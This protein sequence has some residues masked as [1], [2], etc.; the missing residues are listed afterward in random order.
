[1]TNLLI[2]GFVLKALNHLTE[3]ENWV[4]DILNKHEGKCLQINL[5]IGSYQVQINQASWQKILDEQTLNPDVTFDVSQDAI[6]AFLGE[7]KASAIKFVKMSGDVDFAADLNTIATNLNWE[8]EEDLSRII[9]DAPAY[10]ISREMKEIALAGKRA[11]DEF[12][13]GL[14][15]YLV[16]ERS[17]ILG[18]FEFEQF[19]KDLRELRDRLE[20]TEKRVIKINSVVEEKI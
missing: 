14:K 20:R 9:G 16:E 5:P 4:K 3:Q 15:D 13:G 1:M 12:K 8:Y 17:V 7:G 19:K 6:W 2:P 18:A 10:R 11:L